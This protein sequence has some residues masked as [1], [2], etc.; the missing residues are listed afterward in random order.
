MAYNVVCIGAVNKS[1]KM[2]YNVVCMGAANKSNK[3]WRTM[4]SA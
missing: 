3:I 2:A 1:N 4:W